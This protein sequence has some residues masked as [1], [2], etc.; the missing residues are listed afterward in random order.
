MKLLAFTALAACAI[1]LPAAAQG[2][3]SLTDPQTY[4]RGGY[5]ELEGGSPFQGATTEFNSAAGEGTNKGSGHF[6]AGYFGGAIFGHKLAPGISAELEGVYFKNRYDVAT[7]FTQQD[8]GHSR[9]YGGLANL[10]FSLPYDYHVT[11]RFAVVPYV[12]VGAGYGQTAYKTGYDGQTFLDDGQSGLLWQ[13]KTGVELKTGTPVSFDFGYR[14][15]G[16]PDYHQDFVGEG[17]ASSF[18]LKTHVQAATA[19]IKY[20]F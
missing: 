13:A 20:S 15:M 14:Y 12:A 3:G 2:L 16:T 9:T 5:V 6:Q 4:L 18:Q 8:A 17:G 11:P 19:G 1:A 10:K 7:E